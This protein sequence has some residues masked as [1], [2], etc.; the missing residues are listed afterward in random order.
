MNT[1]SRVLYATTIL[2]NNILVLVVFCLSYV[3]VIL[4]QML[5]NFGVDISES[6][7]SFVNA[8]I[9]TNSFMNPYLYTLHNECIKME[10]KLLGKKVK[11]FVCSE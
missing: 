6:V 10:L 7:S 5:W 2:R 8:L 11:Q 1:R 4:T 3:P 9:Y